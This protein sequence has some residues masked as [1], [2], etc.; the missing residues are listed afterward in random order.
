MRD[1]AAKFDPVLQL[2]RCPKCG[3]WYNLLEPDEP[4]GAACL[5]ARMLDPGAAAAARTARE[6]Q[7]AR[8]Q[9]EAAERREARVREQAEREER[10][11]RDRARTAASKPEPPAQATP[12]HRESR[13]RAPA[14]PVPRAGTTAPRPASKPVT[15]PAATR[16]VPA[17]P[18]RPTRPATT[19]AEE[20]DT[21]GGLDAAAR[22]DR[23]VERF[24]D[25]RRPRV[26]RPDTPGFEPVSEI[27][28]GPT[29]GGPGV[30]GAPPTRQGG[31]V[32]VHIA[33]S[34][35]GLFDPAPDPGP[36][37]PKL[38]LVSRRGTR[39]P[40]RVSCA[41]CRVSGVGYWHYASSNRGPVDLCALCKVRVFDRSFGHADASRFSM[42]G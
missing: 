21:L 14:P 4:H 18:L 32:R 39:A 9:R 22:A 13:S 1:K 11:R 38:R 7:Y 3:A 6:A 27:A 31:S 37:L 25:D 40:G 34:G 35:A 26:L 12:G 8:E 42:R 41:E 36:I 10:R 17:P 24:R 29:P 33:G 19:R 23:F 16:P 5:V 20:R 28:G 30:G 2:T 15:R